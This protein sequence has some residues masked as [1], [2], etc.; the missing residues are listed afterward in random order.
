MRSSVRWAL[1]ESA[2][3]QG[4]DSG[5]VVSFCLDN[6][7]GAVSLA[8]GAVVEAARVHLVRT[9][10]VTTTIIGGTAL[11][12]LTAETLV[13]EAHKL[14]RTVRRLGLIDRRPPSQQAAESDTRDMTFW[15]HARGSRTRDGWP[16]AIR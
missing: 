1:S 10:D 2:A 15:L 9:M 8:L 3:Q 4:N 6:P 14:A 5:G 12:G 7:F 16:R 13:N 11:S